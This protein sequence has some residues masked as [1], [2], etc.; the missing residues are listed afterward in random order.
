MEESIL[1]RFRRKID[2]IVMFENELNIINYYEK[3]IYEISPENDTTI[4]LPIEESTDIGYLLELQA[5]TFDSAVIEI[6][7]L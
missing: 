2:K 5:G 7:I 6:V 3:A 4:T 1:V